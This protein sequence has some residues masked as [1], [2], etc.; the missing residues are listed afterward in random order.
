MIVKLG[1]FDEDVLYSHGDI[2]RLADWSTFTQK[3]MN[4]SKTAVANTQTS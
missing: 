4:M 2:T 3:Q 1:A